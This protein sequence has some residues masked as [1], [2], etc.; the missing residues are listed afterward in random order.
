MDLDLE[1]VMKSIGWSLL[2]FRRLLFRDN[3]I[4]IYSNVISAGAQSP[5]RSPVYITHATQYCPIHISSAI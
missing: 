3:D 1:E 5:D 4:S 2:S